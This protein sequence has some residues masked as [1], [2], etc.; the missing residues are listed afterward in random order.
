MSEFSMFSKVFG[1]ILACVLH[2]SSVRLTRDTIIIFFSFFSTACFFY[3]HS[4]ESLSAINLYGQLMTLM[5]LNIV[6]Q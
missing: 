2:V 6:T 3:G 5:L 1:C 4:V